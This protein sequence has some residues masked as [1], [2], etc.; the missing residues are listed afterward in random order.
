[1]AGSRESTEATSLP[2]LFLSGSDSSSSRLLGW[3]EEVPRW[4]E[5]CVSCPVVS[6][7]VLELTL[8]ALSW[9]TSL[10]PH[11]KLSPERID[12]QTGQ[13]LVT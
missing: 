11:P 7:E 6:M 5:E 1:M 2:H 8:I 9:V 4:Q 12:P 3:Y 13:V 10:S